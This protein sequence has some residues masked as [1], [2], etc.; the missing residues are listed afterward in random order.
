MIFRGHLE[1]DAKVTVVTR[2]EVRP[3]EPGVRVR[4]DLYNGA[5]DPNT[6]FLADGF[7][8][9]DNGL[10]PFVPAKG[11]GF[12][13]PNLDLLHLDA[14]WREWPFLAARSQSAP[15]TS[16]AAISCDRAQGAGFNST[17]L[18]AAGVPLE[19][20]APRRRV[21][22]RTVHPR[23]T[24]AGLAPAVAEAMHVRT[25]VHGDPPAVIVS[26]RLVAN[27]VPVNAWAGRAAS[28]LFYEPAA[29]ANPDDPAAS[30]PATRWSRPATGRSRWRCRPS[31]SYRVQPY[32][33]GLRRPPP[34]R[35]SRWATPT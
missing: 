30:P 6:L 17:T 8:W 4:T 33:F 2:Y 34:R 12:V 16:Y 10:L 3:C 32:A 24:G 21:S 28:L 5:P 29:G 22:L 1:S 9:G 20:H 14:A 27:G 35:R 15:D 18:T 23:R 19:R 7:F 31:R 11:L 13:Q 25:L 26:G